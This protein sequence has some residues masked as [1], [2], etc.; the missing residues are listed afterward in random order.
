MTGLK[1][2]KRSQERQEPLA[3]DEATRVLGGYDLR[4][5]IGARLRH[6]ADLPGPHARPEPGGARLR[7]VG[8]RPALARGQHVSAD[9]GGLA[10]SG[11]AARR[12]LAPRARLGT[13]RPPPHGTR[14]RRARDGPLGVPPAAGP[15]PSPRPQVPV[16]GGGL[17]GGA[18]RSRPDRL[19]EPE[20]RVPRQRHGR[21][22]LRH[23]QGRTRGAPPLGHARGGA[24]GDLR[25]DRGLLQSAAC[26]LG[27]GLPTACYF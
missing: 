26:A 2:P 15:G 13:G 1:L 7:G 11:G 9:R 23:P 17:P 8:T 5:P 21:A 12:A 3:E 19:D 24:D 20:R 18:G 16:H 14:A 27:A 6:S 25:V 4:H 10:L 22:L